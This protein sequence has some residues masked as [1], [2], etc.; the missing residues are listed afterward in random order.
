MIFNF[1]KEWME[2]SLIFFDEWPQL[3]RRANRKTDRLDGLDNAGAD[4]TI[5]E[6]Q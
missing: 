2:Y 5:C 3:I 6:A 1:D 4:E